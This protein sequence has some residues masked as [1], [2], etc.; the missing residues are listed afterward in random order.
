MLFGAWKP[1]TKAGLACL[2]GAAQLQ[3]RLLV[4]RLQGESKLSGLL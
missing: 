4:R 2:Q 3:V 1:Q